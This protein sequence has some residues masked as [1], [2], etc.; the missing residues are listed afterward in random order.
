MED[1]TNRIKALSD[2]A[3]IPMIEVLIRI[4]AEAQA[5]ARTGSRAR[6]GTVDRDRSEAARSDVGRLGQIIHFLRYR[7]LATNT[8]AGD[9]EL[10]KEIARKL[11]AKNDWTGEISV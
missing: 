4:D 8:S 1:L 7:T 10:C 11:Q 9:M 2:L 6:R 3:R 5:R